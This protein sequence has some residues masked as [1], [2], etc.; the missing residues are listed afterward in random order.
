M[1][2]LRT[3]AIVVAAPLALAVAGLFHPDLLTAATA[4]RWATLHIVLL[5]VF[6]VLALGLVVPLWGRPG[7]DAAGIAAVTAWVLAFVYATFYTGLDTVAG[8]A[9]GTVARNATDQSTVGASV[10]ALF[11]TG[12]RLGYVGAYAFGA[13]TLAAAVALFLRHGPR[14]LP[15]SVV[16]LAASYSFLD[17]HIFWPRGVLTMLAFAAGFTLIVFLS[18]PVARPPR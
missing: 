11:D 10:Q 17:S 15:G 12:D 14:T 13:A 3:I 4:D 9:A 5:P 2:I 7:R 8:V 18:Q 6:P 1:R 16:L